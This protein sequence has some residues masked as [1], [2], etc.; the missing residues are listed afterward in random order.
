MS[1]QTIACVFARGGSQGIPRK[2]LRLLGGKPLVGIAVETA[3]ESGLVDRVVISTDDSEIADVARSY[4]AEV[5]FM[6]PAELARS[7][8]PEWLAWRHAVKQLWPAGS[9]ADDA[10]ISVPPT[11]PLRAVEDVD[12]VINMLREG[13]AD[14]VVTMTPSARSPYFNMVRVDEAGRAS[15]LVEQGT[16]IARRQDAPVSYDL[17]TVAYAVRPTFVLSANATFEG[18]VRGV[19]VPQERALDIDTEF[20]LR[21]AACLLAE[22]TG[23]GTSR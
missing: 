18:M 22:R 12:A 13:D 14:V 4:G 6:R 15:L 9:G 7:D 2:N 8:S 23:E 3:R 10:L 20:D 1:G 21:I 19:I 11:A 16:G 5:P 17:T